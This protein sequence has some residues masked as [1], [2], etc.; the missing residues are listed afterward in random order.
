[1]AKTPATARFE[2]EI[3]SGLRRWLL[4]S[5]EEPNPAVNLLLR[6]KWR[7]LVLGIYSSN[8]LQFTLLSFAIVASFS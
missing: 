8:F 2:G 1:M 6:L 3:T 7:H 4:W 5:L